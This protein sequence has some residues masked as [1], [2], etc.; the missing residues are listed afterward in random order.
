MDK[1]RGRL[2]I[3]CGLPGAGKTTVATELAERH[4]GVRYSPDD[5]MDA[6]SINLWDSARRD[7]IE[8]LQWQQARHILALGGVA[9]IEWGTWARSE[10]DTLRQGARALGAAVELIY[11]DAP[12]DTLLERVNR[13]GREVPPI[14]R[15]MLEDARATFQAPTAEELALYDPPA[16]AFSS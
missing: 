12:I 11:L 13:R 4:N 9:I 14:D 16:K 15:A 1:P 2:I 10:R 6:M 7:A 3:I 8:T 5:W